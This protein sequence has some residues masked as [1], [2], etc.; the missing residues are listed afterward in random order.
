MNDK[1]KKPASG[2]GSLPDGVELFDTIFREE[3]IAE[4]ERSKKGKADPKKGAVAGGAKSS[5]A[6]PR[7][8]TPG[9]AGQRTREVVSKPATQSQ[10]LRRAAGAP[11][12]G[13]VVKGTGM[14]KRAERQIHFPVAKPKTAELSPL[15]T[16]TITSGK[17]TPQEADLKPKGSKT[18][19]D[20][21]LSE[22]KAPPKRSRSLKLLLACIGLI[23]LAG[24]AFQYFVIEDFVGLRGPFKEKKEA[25][26]TPRPG[27]KQKVPIKMAAERPMPP[28]APP[29]KEQEIK[30]PAPVQ[31]NRVP[32]KEA[33]PA[34]PQD[35]ALP[36]EAAPAVPQDR[37]P[38]KAA[39]PEAKPARPAAPESPPQ[40]PR[41]MAESPSVYPYSIY[42]GSYQDLKGAER[43]VSVYSGTGLSPYWTK[44]DLGEKGIWYRVFAGRFRTLR[45]A[46]AFIRE[47]RIPG[48]EAQETLPAASQGKTLAKTSVPDIK[49]APP[50]GDESPP[51]PQRA[52]A[53]SAPAYPYSIY[54]GSYQDL[55]GA[56]AA[57]SQYAQMGL[58]AYWSKI[59]LGDKGIWYRVFAGYFRT[60]GEAKDLIKAKQIPEAESKNTQYAVLTG[61]Y[62]SEAD[63]GKMLA[64]LVRFGFSPYMIKGEAGDF[65]VY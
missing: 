55:E 56:R 3:L 53:D 32:A 18:K 48:A 15:K 2:K 61:V 27:V 65:R 16:N 45:E 9:P 64:D 41:A 42:L 4:K 36:K 37:A 44:V 33:A 50:A 1:R 23:L 17:V 54:L 30:E 24:A 7:K 43:A 47:K 35:K 40:P 63:A 46:E 39:V 10:R 29:A 21:L 14:M 52:M 13:S 57:V 19:G 58:S 31:E 8:T 62:R 26:P 6:M 12:E 51:Q 20:Q 11:K 22:K 25:P 5:Q 34:V 60:R 28:P 38:P 49:P 59:D